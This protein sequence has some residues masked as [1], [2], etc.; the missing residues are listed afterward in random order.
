MSLNPSKIE[1]MVLNA[2]TEKLKDMNPL[3]CIECGVCAYSCPAKRPLLS[4]VRLAKKIIKEG[5]EK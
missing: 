5:G 3:S 2:H 1:A 4:A